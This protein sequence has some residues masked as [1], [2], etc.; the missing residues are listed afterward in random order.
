M[1][2]SNADLEQEEAGKVTGIRD[3]SLLQ[4]HNLYF[5]TLY[6]VSE[7][8]FYI[9]KSL[10]IDMCCIYK[11]LYETLQAYFLLNYQYIDNVQCSVPLSQFG[12][13]S[14]HSLEHISSDAQVVVRDPL[15]AAAICI[16]GFLHPPEH[17]NR[18]INKAFQRH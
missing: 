16:R 3:F 10:L 14:G 13:A 7:N 4:K 18:H 8:M 11:Y 1:F 15:Q 17:Q 5:F 2:W 12:E 6:K 9:N